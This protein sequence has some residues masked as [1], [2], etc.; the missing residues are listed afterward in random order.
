[1]S[2]DGFIG[3]KK[4]TT[5]LNIPAQSSIILA[6]NTKYLDENLN[7]QVYKNF[8][9]IDWKHDLNLVLTYKDKSDILNAHLDRVKKIKGADQSFE[10][11]LIN[12]RRIT[13]RN[14]ERQEN[15]RGSIRANPGKYFTE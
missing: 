7:I 9:T 5:H 12:G 2:I 4:A 3:N 8:P 11:I 6:K 15:I 10:K 13:T 1:V 14:M